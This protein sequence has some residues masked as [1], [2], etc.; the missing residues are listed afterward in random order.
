MNKDL[1]KEIHR[2]HQQYLFPCVAN[3]YEEPLVMEHGEEKYLYDIEGKRESN[4]WIS[5][6]AF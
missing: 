5:L 4:I 1:I 3:Y 6:A 2:K